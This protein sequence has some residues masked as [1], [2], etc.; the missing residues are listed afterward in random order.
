MYI[1]LIRK[2]SRDGEPHRGEYGYCN[3]EYDALLHAA[4]TFTLEEQTGR[5]RPGDD[6]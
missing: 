2:C 4:S 3:L 1:D 6:N 5:E